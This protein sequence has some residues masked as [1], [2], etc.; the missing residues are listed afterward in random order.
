VTQ[1]R[2][3]NSFLETRIKRIQLCV[4][5]V[6]QMITR[7]KW[8]SLV[9]AK[10][11]R[12]TSITHVSDSG[13]T[14]DEIGERSSTG[15]AKRVDN[16]LPSKRIEASSNGCF[17]EATDTFGTKYSD[18]TIGVAFE[19]RS[20]LPLFSSPTKA[21]SIYRNVPCNTEWQPVLNPFDTIK[22]I[23]SAFI[24]DSSSDAD[25]DDCSLALYGV[26]LY[27]FIVYPI[28]IGFLKI[29]SVLW[30]RG[31]EYREWRARM[32]TLANRHVEEEPDDDI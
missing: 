17:R 7:Q 3:T 31:L 18:T 26:I 1:R 23:V 21:F 8:F 10:A 6:W 12:Q 19:C 11:H 20:W 15:R 9:F 25:R 4:G 24:E 32:E 22:V 2:I 13:C 14:A 29:P 30:K 28:I 27:L 5:F 16:A